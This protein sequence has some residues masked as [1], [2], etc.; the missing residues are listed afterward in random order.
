[1][2]VA[3]SYVQ[4]ICYTQVVHLLFNHKQMVWPHSLYQRSV[5]TMV[6]EEVI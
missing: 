5:S 4:R 1:M 3:V 6:N 2:S